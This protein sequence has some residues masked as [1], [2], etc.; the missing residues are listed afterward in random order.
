MGTQEPAV[1]PPLPF[2]HGPAVSWQLAPCSQGSGSE[3]HQPALPR[4][5]R[6]AGKRPAAQR[7]FYPFFQLLHVSLVQPVNT[8]TLA[9]RA[10]GEQ[11]QGGLS[12]VR[13]A[14]LRAP[15]EPVTALLLQPPGK[16]DCY[17]APS[18]SSQISPASAL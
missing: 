7:Y 16:T 14:M 13:R 17:C 3:E 4:A 5:A 15:K 6:R 9:P 8:V 1:G 11:R 2:S 12:T 10:T 18:C